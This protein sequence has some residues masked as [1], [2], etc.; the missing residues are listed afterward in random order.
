MNTSDTAVMRDSRPAMNFACSAKKSSIRGAGVAAVAFA[1]LLASCKDNA[2]TGS[3]NKMPA[4]IAVVLGAGQSATVATQLA[5][6][7]TVRITD[8]AGDAVAGQ[9]VR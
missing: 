2:A 3:E 8:G 5:S 4:S 1:C 6:P 7:V 9:L